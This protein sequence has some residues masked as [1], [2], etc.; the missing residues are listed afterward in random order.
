MIDDFRM[1]LLVYDCNCV[2]IITMLITKM[3]SCPRLSSRDR[4]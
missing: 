3:H 2:S 4:S 1:S